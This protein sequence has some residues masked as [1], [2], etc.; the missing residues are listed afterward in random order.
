MITYESLKNS[1]QALYGSWIGAGALIES[2]SGTPTTLAS[3]F[4]FVNSEIGAHPHEWKFLKETSTITLTGASSYNLRTL[5]PDLISVYQIYVTNS[6]QD[7]PNVSN[8]EANRL[9]L[10]GY[11]IKGDLLI[12]GSNFP[13]TGTINIQ[14]KSQ[15]LVKDVDGNRKQF[16]EEADDYSVLE[17]ADKNVLIFGLGEWVNWKTDEQSQAQKDKISEKYNKAFDSMLAR[18][19]VSIPLDSMI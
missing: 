15:Y 9:V 3:Y 7:F 1:A 11:T 16:F 18:G 5:F 12:P 17:F 6:A 19:D 4:D 14:Y 13:T 2:D 8:Y 10:D